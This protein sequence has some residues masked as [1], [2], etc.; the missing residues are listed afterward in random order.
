MQR[1]DTALQALDWLAVESVAEIDDLARGASKEDVDAVLAGAE[2]LA[3]EA[4]VATAGARVADDAEVALALG[5]RGVGADDLGE[6]SDVLAIDRGG[7]EE[8]AKG[9]LVALY[10]G[11]AEAAEGRAATGVEA[12]VRD[13]GRAV[14]ESGQHA[15]DA[16]VDALLVAALAR[17]R[18]VGA[19]DRQVVRVGAEGGEVASATR[20]HRRVRQAPQHT[21]ELGVDAVGG[22]ALAAER[23]VHG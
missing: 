4:D 20:C 11:V 23:Q 21:A 15:V 7:T 13:R 3:A 2:V 18:H 8:R 14:D 16:R 6:A 12:A 10:R 9:D 19:V 5:N 22:R 17:E 1:L